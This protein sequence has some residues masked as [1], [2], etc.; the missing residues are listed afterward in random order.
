MSRVLNIYKYAYN[1]L[2]SLHLFGCTLQ[3]ALLWWIM[4]SYTV[5][6]GIGRGCSRLL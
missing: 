5:T 4:H 1:L 2:P 6:S 3:F